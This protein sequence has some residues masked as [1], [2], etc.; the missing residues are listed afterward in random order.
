MTDLQEGR[1]QLQ[2]LQMV[3]YR[4]RHEARIRRAQSHADRNVSQK[5]HVAVATKRD[6]DCLFEFACRHGLRCWGKHTAEQNAFFT[7][8]DALMAQEAQEQCAYCAAD[9]CRFGA[10]C[11]GQTAMHPASVGREIALESEGAAAHSAQVVSDSHSHQ[12]VRNSCSRRRP[13]R[14]KRCRG[15]KRRRA[16][17]YVH[18]QP[19]AQV[20]EDE[21]EAVPLSA[22]TQEVT[23][24]CE[25]ANQQVRMQLQENINE[26]RLMIQEH[27]L[28]IKMATPQPKARALHLDREVETQHVRAAQVKETEDDLPAA[29]ARF[30]LSH[31]NCLEVLEYS[32]DLLREEEEDSAL[33]Q[34]LCV[35]CKALLEFHTPTQPISLC[36][37]SCG[38]KQTVEALSASTGGSG[39]VA[40]VLG[41][42]PEYLSDAGSGSDHTYLSDNY[43][44]DNYLSDNYADY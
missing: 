23:A 4:S 18:V 16:R 3:Q 21:E 22:A 30:G 38:T 12:L 37:Y 9:C 6:C 36:C 25:D 26:T 44:S 31:R 1:R 39:R 5:S 28:A 10:G 20:A 2:E 11:V 19:A 33:S 7:Q 8:R 14:K 24:A 29:L 41:A 17:A 40:G 32:T 43:P 42:P 15:R 34:C 35:E 27:Q 13:H